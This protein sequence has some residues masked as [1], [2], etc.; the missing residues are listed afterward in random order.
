MSGRPISR[1]EVSHLLTRALFW[2][3]IIL[4]ALYTMLPFAYAISISFRTNSQVLVAARYLPED[5]QL[6]N[7]QNLLSD[8]NFMRTMLNSSVVASVTVLLALVVGS[9][10]AYAL[11]RVQFRGRMV[12]L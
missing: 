9:F 1:R 10:A 12:V 4:V 3:V 11:G 5:P 7:Y 2:L 8:K 6:T